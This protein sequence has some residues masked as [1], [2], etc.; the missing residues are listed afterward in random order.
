ME[1]DC[2]TTDTGYDDISS[3]AQVTV[4]DPAGTVLAVTQLGTGAVGDE[5]NCSWPFT[6]SAVPEGSK[7]YQIHIGNQARGEVSFTRDQLAEGPAS[8]TLGK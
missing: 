1:A 5:G 2:D 3:G 6:I 7:F 4:T 8:L